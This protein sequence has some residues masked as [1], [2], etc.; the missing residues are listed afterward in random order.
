MW[1]TAGAVLV[2]LGVVLFV[3]QPVLAGRAAPLDR[4][5]DELT[6]AEARK[7]VALLALRDVE[8]DYATGK[9]DDDDYES[10][11]G[12]LAAEALEALRAE[13]VE[14]RAADAGEGEPGGYPAARSLDELE[15]EIA[16]YRAA[17][18]RGVP[19]ATC[20]HVNEAGSRF[21]AQC[22]SPLEEEVPAPA[23]AGAPDSR[24]RFAG[25][26]SEQDP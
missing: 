3:L 5:D 17:L 15:R 24:G 14:A 23:G 18:R 12:E 7:R 9:L 13:E 26:S 19:C 20:G 16:A 4:D 8:Y 1:L 21:C 10:L 11:R 6:E 25:G 2:A 22:G